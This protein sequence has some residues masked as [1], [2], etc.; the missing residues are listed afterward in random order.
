LPSAVSGRRT[1]IREEL[2]S[3][4]VTTATY[5]SPHLFQQ[6]YFIKT[7]VAGAMPICEDVSA[8]MISLPL[9]DTMTNEEVDFVVE[10]LQDV[11]GV[12]EPAWGWRRRSRSEQTVPL[13]YG[14]TDHT[15]LESIAR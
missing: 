11:I 15:S 8:R 4:G 13:A 1:A 3:R 7:C 10:C 6:P 2:A 9:Y 5:F 14:A 12:T